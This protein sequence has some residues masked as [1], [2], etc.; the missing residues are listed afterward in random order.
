MRPVTDPLDRIEVFFGEANNAEARVYARLDATE[1]PGDC[2]LTGRVIGPICEYAHTLSAAIP[3]TMKRLPANIAAPQ[4]PS[5][6][7]EA[8]VPDPCFWSTELPFLYRVEVELLRETELLA[9]TQRLLGIRPLGVFRRRLVFEAKPW[10]PRGMNLVGVP[11]A[12]LSDWRAADLVMVVE[13]PNEVLCGDASRL[14]ALVVAEVAGS[15]SDLVSE[16]QRLSRWPA[17]VIAG[18]NSATPLDAGIRAKAKNLLLAQSIGPES[19]IEPAAW[20]DVGICESSDAADLS[21]RATGCRL[22]VIA[23]RPSAWRDDLVQ[24]RAECD[25]LQR[26]L[27]GT[28]DF[29]GYLV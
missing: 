24:A 11:E 23:R 2:H 27:A 18:L 6:L 10:V 4:P 28:G 19:A 25:L 17:V 26:D 5:L 1:A 12:P 14:G 13:C 20:A 21:R 7:A 29:A 15:P 16:V 9:K 3:L 8:V 22:P